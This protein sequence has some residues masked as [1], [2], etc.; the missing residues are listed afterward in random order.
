MPG[1]SPSYA[2][3]VPERNRLSVGIVEVADLERSTALFRDGFG[4]DLRGNVISLT[5]S[6]P[7]E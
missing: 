5:E 7:H 6:R 4:I 1:T 2:P 3:N